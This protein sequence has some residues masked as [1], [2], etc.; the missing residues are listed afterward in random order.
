VI[1]DSLYDRIEA[2]AL[3]QT[4]H[5]PYVDR[6]EREHPELI[7][8]DGAN[9]LAS[10]GTGGAKLIYGF[11]HERAFVERFPA[12]FAK[13]LPRIRRVYRADS[14][15]FRLTYAP[16]RPLIEPVLKQ[17]W[18]RPTRDW[19]EFSLGRGAKLQ[20]A[21]APRGVRFRDATPDDLAD[22]IRID[23]ECFPNTP[24]P[25]DAMRARLEEESAI[26]ALAGKEI[27][28]FAMFYAPEPGLGWLSV[29]AVAEE[30]RGGGIGEALT[31]RV[32]KRLFSEGAQSVG[33]TTDDD[34][35][36][37]IRLYVRLGFRQTR[38]GRDY[39]RPTEPRAIAALKRAG[40]GTFIRFGGWR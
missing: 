39:S 7:I 24:I 9:V 13:L 10:E 35:G 37:A 31:T 38:A 6:L 23:R 29:L 25:P 33:L 27:A 15:R 1:T 20:T 28:G 16:A 11:E 14:V 21:A 30:H 22:L 19:M 12:M 32:A 34:N 5:R 26:V 18:F 4:T 40:E 36:D 8:E 3:H 17:H 2:H